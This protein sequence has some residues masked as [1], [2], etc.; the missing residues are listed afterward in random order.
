M[1]LRDALSGHF[2]KVKIL[3]HHCNRDPVVSGK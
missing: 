2:V 3:I 1:S